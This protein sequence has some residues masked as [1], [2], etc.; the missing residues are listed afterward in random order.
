MHYHVINLCIDIFL[1]S[2]EERIF[3]WLVI[4]FFSFFF[5]L[6][7]IKVLK[8]TLISIVSLFSPWPKLLMS[9]EEGNQYFQADKN[10]DGRLIIILISVSFYVQYAIGD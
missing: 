9:G 1:Q 10:F 2:N 6:I 4:P 3:N 7:F 5:F 8:G